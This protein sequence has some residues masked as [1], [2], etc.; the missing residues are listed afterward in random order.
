MRGWDGFALEVGVAALL[1]AAA[2][3]G[4]R[5]IALA[6]GWL[7]EPDPARRL[8]VVPVPRLGGVGMFVG[9]Y[10]AWGTLNSAALCLEW[11]PSQCPLGYGTPLFFLVG[12]LDDV[13]GRRRGLPAAAK[14]LLQAGAA[15]VVV[16]MGLRFEGRGSGPVTRRRERRP[17]CRP[18]RAQAR[19][20]RRK[21]P[22]K[23]QPIPT[24]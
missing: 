20:S 7:D 14:L 5:A 23:S 24:C 18:S 6:R 22:P 21:R 9:F 16:A 15:G 13:R 1:T 4:V 2:T 10:L 8:H 17:A 11:E 19:R 3:A 12:L